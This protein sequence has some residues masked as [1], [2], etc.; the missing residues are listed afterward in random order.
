MPNIEIEIFDGSGNRVQHYVGP[1]DTATDAEIADMVAM[2]E[3]GTPAY[4]AA[5]LAKQSLTTG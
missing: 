4:L 1:A 2:I 3:N 5:V